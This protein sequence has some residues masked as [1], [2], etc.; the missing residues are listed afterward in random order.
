VPDWLAEEFAD[1][2]E[3]LGIDR[4]ARSPSSSKRLAIGP[5]KSIDE[6]FSIWVRDVRQAGLV[7]MGNAAQPLH[8]EKGWNMYGVAATPLAAGATS[9]AVTPRS[10]QTARPADGALSATPQ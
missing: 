2:G 3:D 9:A 5:G 7:T 1:T 10:G 6:T 8:G 4:Q